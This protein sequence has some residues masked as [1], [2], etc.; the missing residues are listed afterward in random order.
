MSGTE[1]LKTTIEHFKL[2]SMYVTRDRVILKFE[3][4]VQ[5]YVAVSNFGFEFQN[6][7][8][9]VVSFS[10]TNSSEISF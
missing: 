6:S 7:G 3:T 9:K 2:R 5:M 10:K 1:L 4:G 8:G